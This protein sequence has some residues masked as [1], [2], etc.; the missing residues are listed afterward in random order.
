VRPLVLCYHAVSD[1]WPHL[2]S[3]PPDALERQ[4]RALLAR[5]YEP[6]PAPAVLAGRGRIFHVTFDDAFVSVRNALPILERLAVPATLFVC[7][8]FAAGGNPLTI[9]ELARE[10]DERPDELGTM[11]W[12]EIREV[13]ARSDVEIGAHTL[14]HPHLRLLGDEELRCE[15]EGSRR[16]IEDELGRPCN[17]FAYPY[18]EFD[19]R[20]MLAA[21][22]AG[23]DAAFAFRPWG[24]SWSDRFRLPREPIFRSEGARAFA[25]KTSPLGRSRPAA[26]LRRVRHR[27]A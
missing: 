22:S 4:L 10:V 15:I 20:V 5:G 18:G 8:G 17:L 21:E 7:P 14:S 27:V 23:F 16:Q 9:A 12:R 13:A 26:L 2:L 6:V 11:S 3:V 19:R 1:T 24:A 25:L